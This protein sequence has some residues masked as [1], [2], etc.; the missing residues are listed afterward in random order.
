MNSI[1]YLS[2]GVLSPLRPLR[3]VHAV[4]DALESIP[5]DRATN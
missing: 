4:G 5:G 3:C 2:G 1:I